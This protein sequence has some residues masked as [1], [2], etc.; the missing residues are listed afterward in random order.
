[1]A[2]Y[3]TAMHRQARRARGSEEG[4]RREGASSREGGRKVGWKTMVGSSCGRTEET[5]LPACLY[6]CCGVCCCEGKK[7]GRQ[8]L[9]FRAMLAIATQR[10]VALDTGNARTHLSAASRGGDAAVPLCLCVSPLFAKNHLF[11]DALSS[12]RLPTLS[13][14][15]T[16]SK[17]TPTPTQAMPKAEEEE[18]EVGT[19]DETEEEMRKRH[20]SEVRV[21]GRSKGG[22]RRRA[23][24]R[25]ETEGE[26]E[27]VR[28]DGGRGL[29]RRLML[30]AKE[31]RNADETQAHSLCVHPTPIT[32]LISSLLLPLLLPPLPSLFPS[33]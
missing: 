7:D 4:C 16:L 33:N 19:A 25:G 28:W 5:G 24:G 20:K 6:V 15:G 10:L 23:G 27:T 22:G 26:S 29:G 12:P 3:S 30:V 13:I 31:Q 21:S 11:H 18:V 1:M 32:Y 17:P 8:L 2:T 9:D 14:T